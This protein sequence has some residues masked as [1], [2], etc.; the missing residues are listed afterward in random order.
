MDT[1]TQAPVAKT[2]KPFAIASITLII[3][4]IFV[5]WQA[6][7]PVL[8]WL[9]APD[10][11]AEVYIKFSDLATSA[12]IVLCILSVAVATFFKKSNIFLMVSLFALT[13]AYAI[14]SVSCLK[15]FF[16]SLG[17]EFTTRFTFEYGLYSGAYVCFVLGFLVIGLT[18]IFARMGKEKLTNLW[19]LATVLFV[20]AALCSMINAFRT[21]II[22]FEQLGWALEMWLDYGIGDTSDIIVNFFYTLLTPWVFFGSAA[23]HFISSILMGLYLKKLSK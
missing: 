6:I 23:M 13:W 19:I 1:V 10:A 5:F 15:G 12:F 22:N 3:G 17:D 4:A 2:K 8:K 18:A 9:I 14:P 21:I 11:P 7:I 16:F 20:I